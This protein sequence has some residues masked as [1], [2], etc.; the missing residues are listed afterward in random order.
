MSIPGLQRFYHEHFPE[1]TPEETP[2]RDIEQYLRILLERDLAQNTKRRY[3]ESLSAFFLWAMKRPRY[4]GISGNPA[5]VL[6][7]ELPKEVN[8]RP[9]CAT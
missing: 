9:D 3:L 4:E 7:E 8:Q 2:V 5:A 6:L 1:L